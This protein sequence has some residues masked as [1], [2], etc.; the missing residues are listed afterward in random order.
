MMHVEVCLVMDSNFFCPSFLGHHS[1]SL[2][3]V[4][5]TISVLC[6]GLFGPL[7]LLQPRVNILEYPGL[8]Q[9]LRGRE[10]IS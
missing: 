7:T 8:L 2:E 10:E 6:S 5:C 4:L 9:P 1:W 3:P